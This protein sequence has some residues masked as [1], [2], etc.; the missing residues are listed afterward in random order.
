MKYSRCP[1]KRMLRQS[2]VPLTAGDDEKG[3]YTHPDNRHANSTLLLENFLP[4]I[5]KA[6]PI[7]SGE[8]DTALLGSG[9]SWG[10]AE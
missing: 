7:T 3:D 8:E 2:L 9:C 10:E 1:F 6:F 5:D 4:V